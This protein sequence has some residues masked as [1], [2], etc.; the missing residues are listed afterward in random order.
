[1]KRRT[2][3]LL[4]LTSI[5]LVFSLM[6]PALVV[7]ASATM[8]MPNDSSISHLTVDSLSAASAMALDVPQGESTAMVA[9][10]FY[11]TV[12]LESDGTVVAVGWN[13]DGQCNVGGW[14]GIVQIAAAGGYHTVGLKSDGTVVAVGLNTYGQC[15]VEEWDLIEGDQSPV[16]LIFVATVDSVET[17]D[18]WGWCPLVVTAVVERQLSPIPPPDIVKPGDEVRLECWGFNQPN[19]SID[20]PLSNGDRIEVKVSG[21]Q[22]QLPDINTLPDYIKKLTPSYLP[23][24]TFDMVGFNRPEPF[25]EG[26]VIYFGAEIVNQGT[27][28]ASGF[29][30]DVYLDDELFDSGIISLG[31]GE[32]ATLWTDYPWTTT[33]GSHTVRWVADTTNAVVESNEKNNE[34]SRTF[35]VGAVAEWT[36]MAYLD[37]DNDLE[38]YVLKNLNEMETVDSTP[39]VIVLTL[40]DRHPKYDSSD[41]DWTTTRLYKI[42]KDDNLSKIGSELLEDFG[43]LNMGEAKTLSDF[44]KKC[45][46]E[47]PARKYALII[48]GHGGGWQGI[49]EDQ[50]SHY[51]G[52]RMEELKEALQD[53]GKPIDL[54]AFDS[55]L[56]G[57]IEVAYQIES[58]DVHVMVGS[59]DYLRYV[60]DFI[61]EYGFP[62]DGVLSALTKN[63]AMDA[64]ELARTIVSKFEE[65]YEG[66]PPFLG[67]VS[68]IDLSKIAELAD[69]VDELSKFLLE[70]LD[71]YKDE[72][73]DLRT[74]IAH[75]NEEYGKEDLSNPNDDF[76]YIDLYYFAQLVKEH[77]KEA[78]TY[79]EAIMNKIDI[80]KTDLVVIT[81]WHQSLHGNSHGLSIWFPETTYQMYNRASTLDFAH[82]LVWDEFLNEYTNKVSATVTVFAEDSTGSSLTNVIFSVDGQQYNTPMPLGLMRGNH[83]FDVEAIVFKEDI[84][85]FNHWE[86]ETGKTVA[87]STSF[88]YD[89]Q[90]NKWFHAIYESISSGTGIE[91]HEDGQ[92]LFLHVYDGEGRHV[93]LNY[94]LN[95]TE[96]E[97]PGAYYYDSLNGTIIIIVPSDISK[98]RV[99]VDAS[100]AE[101]PMESFN[102]TTYT[103]ADSQISERKDLQS[104]IQKG[105]EQAYTVTHT[106]EGEINMTPSRVSVTR[107]VAICGGIIALGLG[108]YLIIR[109]RRWKVK[110]Q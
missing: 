62:Y 99:V 31:G 75:T 92:K 91:L 33:P 47:Y 109:R 73:T 82:N 107:L 55:C 71:V 69:S 29:R 93:G 19:S 53:V 104:S 68:A 58:C 96:V 46:K 39:S 8:F 49:C 61:F 42:N 17:R 22:E 95:Q 36:V 98:L 6:L 100:Y 12:G 10:G 20:W 77:I 43:E 81:E 89:I 1:M 102:L 18:E 63:S 90:A 51:D 72:V 110:K 14:T 21:G 87:D 94:A 79:A 50:T 86:D 56:M 24:I 5:I 83:R 84:L 37:G 57:M 80:G 35:T 30:V 103:I 52:L 3:L 97:V 23:D 7:G 2:I 65:D 15:N 4:V 105:E 41:G 76:D 74:D 13:D 106:A 26:D 85:V 101:E 66:E 32:S 59:E 64:N 78:Q 27:G 54:I 9:G 60:K 44:I 28:D 11:H 45:M 38:K 108:C 88:S 25:E 70:N 67:T 34:K 16:P 48:G 40:I